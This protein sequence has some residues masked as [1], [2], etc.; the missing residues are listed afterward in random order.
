MA[1]DKTEFIDS[2]LTSKFFDLENNFSECF[3]SG[4]LETT[5]SYVSI[6]ENGRPMAIHN[7]DGR[8][9]GFLEKLHGF[10]FA[11]SKYCI[12]SKREIAVF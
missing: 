10:A 9:S 11:A 12:F 3:Q 4:D 2:A 7:D 6:V 5:Y 1:S 8:M